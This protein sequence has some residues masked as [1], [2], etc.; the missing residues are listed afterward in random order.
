ML[1]EMKVPKG[2]DFTYDDVDVEP[3]CYGFIQSFEPTHRKHGRRKAEQQEKWRQ[4]Q[5]HQPTFYPETR[6][7]KN[8][9]KHCSMLVLNPMG[10]GKGSVLPVRLTQRVRQS[11]RYPKEVI[12]LTTMSR[13]DL[14]AT[15]SF[16]ALT[17]HT[18]SMGGEKQSSRKSVCSDSAGYHTGSMVGAK[19]SVSRGNC[20]ACAGQPTES[21]TG[22]RSTQLKYNRRSCSWDGMRHDAGGV[23]GRERSE[24]AGIKKEAMRAQQTMRRC[25]W[26]SIHQTVKCQ[27]RKNWLLIKR[28]L[29]CLLL[30]SQYPSCCPGKLR[31]RRP[32]LM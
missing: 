10:S 6:L 2:G 22:G 11:R 26:N 21:T 27:F 12:S 18:G 13:W 23:R 19:Q 30:W 16:K 5:P 29:N 15:V 1:I 25:R 17:P 7:I 4:T 24:K 9:L 20:V 31:F 14:C 28:F 3:V 32:Q 8:T